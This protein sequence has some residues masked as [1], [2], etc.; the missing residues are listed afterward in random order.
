MENDNTIDR[1]R[2]FEIPGTVAFEP[3]GGGLT[4]IRIKA[5]G[6]S[7]EVYLHGAHV[8]G[9]QKKGE[10]P[11]LFMSR[12]S[13][14]AGGKAIRGGVPICL[15]WFGPREGDVVHGFARVTEWEVIGTGAT[16]GGGASVRLKLPQSAVPAAW[17]AF[18]AEFTVTVA[19]HL[20]MELSV[21]NADPAR[22]LDFENCLHTYV[23][24][25][26]IREMAVAGLKGV[27]FLDK[28]EKGARKTDPAD[29][30]RITAETNRVYLDTA[31]PVEIHDA[32]L[33]RNVRVL[34]SGSAST[35]VW[36]PWT[37]QRMPDLGEEE[38][39]QMI[40]VESGNV[41]PDK[42][43]LAPGKTVKLKVTLSSE[44]AG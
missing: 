6:G 28:T 30:L 26:D 44:A 33:R 19:D 7:A 40:C 29:A 12:L 18:S 15:P 2:R 3:G 4:R 41:G 1:Y 38:Y 34:K 11:L 13:Q 36:N 5:D 43:A 24:V 37:T 17:P 14:F 9:F 42:L 10:P 31:G 35:V 8:T 22:K 20:A 16:P 23:A 21:T 27:E 39:Q 32:K 25:G